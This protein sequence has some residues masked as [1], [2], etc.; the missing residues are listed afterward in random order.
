M[1]TSF[2]SASIAV[3]GPASSALGGGHAL[4]ELVA[5]P[6]RAGELTVVSLR[7]R[8]GISRPYVFDVFVSAQGVDLNTLELAL[9]GQQACLRMNH[10]SATPRVVYGVVA[11]YRVEGAYRLGEAV[12]LRLRIV[13]RLSLLRRRK[14][15]R[16]FQDKKVDEI[17]GRV[18]DEA[19]VL[20]R[21]QL[22]HNYP[23]RSYC[24][25]YQET[26][27]DFVTRLLAEEGILYR[28]DQP[29][30][31]DDVVSAVVGAASAVAGAVVDV[32]SGASASSILGDV[33]DVV[34]AAAQFFSV[35]ET[36]VMLDSAET[37]PAIASEGAASVNA[38]TLLGTFAP[39]VVGAA[40]SLGISVGGSP[41]LTYRDREGMVASDEHVQAFS[42]SRA[43]RSSSVF[44]TDYDFRRPSL[45]LSAKLDVRGN[46]LLPGIDLRATLGGGASVA[47]DGALNVATAVSASVAPGALL[48]PKQFEIYDHHAAYE[49]TDVEPGEA[50][51]RLQQA[52]TRASVARG[53][54]WCRRLTAGHRFTLEEHFDASANIE[55]VVTRVEHVADVSTAHAGKSKSEFIYT[56]RFQCVPASV[57]FRPKRPVHVHRQVLETATVVGENDAEIH[58]DG[59]GRVQVRFHWDREDTS[60]CWLRVAQNWGGASWGTQ[61]IPRVGM[62]VLVSFLGGDQDRPVVLGCVW[63]S[64]HPP[65][66]PTPREKTKSGFRTQSTP[67]AEGF[68]ELSF[69]DQAGNEQIYV[70]AQRDLVELVQHDHRT[71][72]QHDHETRVERRQS[73]DVGENRQARI[74]GDD[75]EEVTGDASRVVKGDGRDE[76]R[77]KRQSIVGTDLVDAVGGAVQR[78]IGGG[79]T[80]HVGGA[81]EVDVSGNEAVR[82]K[83][84][85][86]LTIGGSQNVTVGNGMG[87]DVAGGIALAAKGAVIADAGE[88]LELKSGKAITLTVGDC[89][90]VL[91]ADGLKVRLK[92]SVFELTKNDIYAASKKVSFIAEDEVGFKKGD[93]FLKL[94]DDA[95]L[96]G[97]KVK[98]FS[99]GA[100]VELDANASVVG[101]QV[102]LNPSGGSKSS[103][104]DKKDPSENE[105]KKHKLKLVLKGPDGKAYANKQYVLTVD[106]KEL[107]SGSTGGDGSIDKEVP[108]NAVSGSVL[109]TIDEDDQLLIPLTF[110]ELAPIEQISGVKARLRN[111]GYF[112]GSIDDVSDAKLAMAIRRFQQAQGLEV[113]GR[114]DAQTRSAIKELAGS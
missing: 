95:E 15:T 73:L 101:S 24:V 89:S 104:P 83:G 44:I 17:I 87:D 49:E 33:G 6:Y 57:T 96:V 94:T 14:N 68:N 82:V 2:P 63:N 111:L 38:A 42:T 97:S 18:L 12:R 19:K 26:D 74:G 20:H 80:E 51:Q 25:Q 45:R 41:I 53:K 98:L 112:L 99:S 56:N 54:S 1:S 106:D 36:L 7:G 113:T 11:S 46:Q 72:V 67:N 35:G 86:R 22:T 100:S 90:L 10:A 70:R 29:N 84:W 58:T 40:A 79:L 9:L 114:I 3:T 65:S 16:I 59:F 43:I 85:G 69:E 47:V 108:K 23:R 13:P 5:G 78:S 76:V 27:L 81:V 48:D 32:A 93:A 55:W 21:F 107:G 31:P 34:G 71:T 8:E 66:F 64:E 37:Y 109:L 75:R 88:E 77:G 92:D 61:F 50:V 105:L 30:G 103:G 4:F 28:F 52:R 62:E 39:G 102:K 110:G 91:D 60:S